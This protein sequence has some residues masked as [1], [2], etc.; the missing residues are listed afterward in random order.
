M[1]GL[2]P[3]SAPKGRRCSWCSWRGQPW[4]LLPCPCLSLVV[5]LSGHLPLVLGNP[6]D[7]E[8]FNQ[9]ELIFSS[10]V[11][12]TVSRDTSHETQFCTEPSICCRG[13]LP[14]LPQLLMSFPMQ[15]FQAQ[16]RIPPL[17]LRRP[18]TACLCSARCLMPA[19]PAWT[20]ATNTPRGII[21]K[22][23]E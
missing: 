6:F 17:I 18:S 10:K 2:V 7:L 23:V 16:L 21:S 22:Y 19:P 15:I 11:M 1:T 9:K 5:L 12:L 8:T 13:L 14:A 3:S 20:L 4:L